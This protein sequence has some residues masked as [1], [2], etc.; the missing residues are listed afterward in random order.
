MPEVGPSHRCGPICPPP[1]RRSAPY[2]ALPGCTLH[3][4]RP[5]H[6][7]RLHSAPMRRASARTSLAAHLA[8]RSLRGSRQ[9]THT[10]NP[11]GRG[12]V[13]L[14]LFD[15][16]EPKLWV[17]STSRRPARGRKLRVRRVRAPEAP[18]LVQIRAPGATFGRSFGVR[19]RCFDPPASAQHGCIES[20]RLLPVTPS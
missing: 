10:H 4:E 3:Q 12:A 19:A 14:A 11:C 16:T 2:A 20:E 1:K 13:P 6:V 8:C 18:S 17:L 5:L 7:D 15:V 9:N